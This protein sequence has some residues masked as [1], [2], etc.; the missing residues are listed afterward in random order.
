MN[1]T[2]YVGNEVGKEN[3]K[4]VAPRAGSSRLV[5]YLQLTE[6]LCLLYLG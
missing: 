3:A 6:Y 4:L 1:A 5:I 2:W